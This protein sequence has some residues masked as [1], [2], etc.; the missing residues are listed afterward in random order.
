MGCEILIYAADLRSWTCSRGFFMQ[1]RDSFP[2]FFI[3]NGESEASFNQLSTKSEYSL[4]IHAVHNG[5]TEKNRMWEDWDFCRSNKLNHEK[6]SSIQLKRFLGNIFLK[7]FFGETEKKIY[8][9][10]FA[11]TR[12]RKMIYASPSKSYEGFFAIFVSFFFFVL[13][14]FPLA[15]NMKNLV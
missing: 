9:P 6:I 14:F 1:L 4:F 15:Y 11:P 2:V 10:F 12:S 7:R 5:V 3:C 13:N 8:F